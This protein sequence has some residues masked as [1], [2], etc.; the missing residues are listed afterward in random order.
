M[1]PSPRCARS[2]S[3]RHAGSRPCFRARTPCGSPRS[4]SAGSACPRGSSRSRA[5]DANRFSIRLARHVTGR[6]KVL[7]FNWCYHGTVDESFATLA[8]GTV[9]ARSG[10]L[11]PP[12]ALAETTR[13]VEFNDVEGLERELAARR[14]GARPHGARAD[15]RRDRPRG[16]GVPRRAARAHA[17]AR[18]AARDRRDAH[19]LLRPGWVHRG[20]RARAG[21]RHDRE[22]DRGRNPGS[23]VRLLRGAGRPACGDDRARGRRRRRHRRDAG[24]ECA[25]VRGDA[26][27]A[28]RGADGGTRSR[29]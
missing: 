22:A 6:P 29:A 7:V 19:D 9:V 8:D 26:S 16:P 12:V 27:D 10:N 13:V 20:A 3:R 24:G 18:L 5:T 17:C 4:S 25:L 21:H 1:R 11:G 14:C 23:G 15:E 28:R 2:Q